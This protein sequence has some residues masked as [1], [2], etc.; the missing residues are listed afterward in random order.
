MGLLLVSSLAPNSTLLGSNPKEAALVDQWISF[1]DSEIDVLLIFLKRILTGGLQYN[2]SYDQELRRR[3]N[4]PLDT[5][6]AYLSKHTFLVGERLSL[7]DISAATVFRGAFSTILGAAE[8]AKYPHTWRWYETVINQPKVKDVLSG[9]KLAE[10]AQQYVPHAKDEKTK[11][12][13]PKAEPKPKPE[14]KKEREAEEEA[15]PL[16][17]EEPKKHNP[18]DDLPKS[19]F[20]LEDWKRAYSNLD[21]RGAGGSLECFYDK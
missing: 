15:D 7:A 2:K 21:T 18:L 17:P 12:E 4:R 11:A 6:E 3:L 14:Q 5:V 16:V 8:R 19:G 1:F 9:G 10:T 13:K 20:N